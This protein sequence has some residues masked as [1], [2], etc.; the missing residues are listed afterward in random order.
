MPP[1]AIDKEYG[2]ELMASEK[3]LVRPLTKPWNGK[4][5]NGTQGNST[6]LQS[7][8]MKQYQW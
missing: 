3:N 8:R 5:S 1:G 4:Q 6:L 7:V 2:E